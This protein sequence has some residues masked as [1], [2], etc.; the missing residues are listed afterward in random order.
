MQ[1]TKNDQLQSHHNIK[2]LYTVNVDL[3]NKHCEQRTTPQ[4]SDRQAKIC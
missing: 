4:A 3:N 1:Y 2:Q